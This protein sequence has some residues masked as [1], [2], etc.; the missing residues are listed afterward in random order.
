[1]RLKSAIKAGCEAEWMKLGLSPDDDGSTESLFV[2]ELKLRT[3][4]LLQS[5]EAIYQVKPDP[6]GTGGVCEQKIRFIQ[7]H[8]F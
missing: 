2:Q 4:C 1:M 3:S 5:R 8:V 7:K 6:K